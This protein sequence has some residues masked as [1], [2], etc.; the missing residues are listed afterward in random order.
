M[1]EFQV[2]EWDPKGGRSGITDVFPLWEGGR[3]GGTWCVL[4]RSHLGGLVDKCG[5]TPWESTEVCTFILLPS[6]C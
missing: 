6:Q 2:G 1:A 5:L 3:F 4:W